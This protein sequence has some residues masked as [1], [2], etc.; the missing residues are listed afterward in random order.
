VHSPVRWSHASHSKGWCR[1]LP[2]PTVQPTGLA[3]YAFCRPPDSR[4]HVSCWPATWVILPGA[5]ICGCVIEFGNIRP[6][7]AGL[8]CWFIIDLSRCTNTD[9][10]QLWLRSRGSHVIKVVLQ[11]PGGT[12]TSLPCP[13]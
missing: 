6:V 9:S 11:G 3:C 4:I 8:P 12:I 7:H 10:L 1:V 13:R 5:W 2:E